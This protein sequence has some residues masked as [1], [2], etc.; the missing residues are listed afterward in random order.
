MR[1]RIYLVIA[2]IIWGSSFLAT[3]DALSFVPTS[4]VLLFRFAAAIPIVALVFRK[5]MRH[6]ID[7]GHIGFG[8]LLGLITFFAFYFQVKGLNYI[9]PG[10][11]AFLTDLYC[12]IVPFLAWAMTGKRPLA[13]NIVAALLCIVGVGLVSLDGGSLRLGIGEG[14]T[15]LGSLFYALQFATLPTFSRNRDIFAL[16]VWY[17]AGTSLCALVTLLLFEQ[18]VPP[19]AIPPRGWIG[20]AYLA[21]VV[22]SIALV[23]QNI[24]M[25]HLP[26]ATGSVIASSE[27]VFA[28][29]FSVAAGAEVLT[30][31]IVCG[32]AVM[33]AG[34]MCSEAL[35]LIVDRR[36]GKAIP[37]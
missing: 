5:H 23:L 28:V 33:F 4:E 1:Y 10:K 29:L 25:A 32:F 11:N 35:P 12:I 15:L 21:V 19:A 14:I 20:L 3:K 6:C 8:L 31:R 22:T 2:T 26:A 13:Y 17:F 30:P 9:T 18:P 16:T 36:K 37:R 34:I 24:G 7:P 27:C